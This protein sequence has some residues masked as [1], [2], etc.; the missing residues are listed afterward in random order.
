VT[1]DIDLN[2][3]ELVEGRLENLGSA[4]TC[5]A[6]S[7]GRA[8]QNTSD[9]YAYVCDG[10]VFR[11][12]VDSIHYHNGTSINNVKTATVSGVST[13]GEDTTIYLTD[14][15]TVNGNLL[16]SSVYHASATAAEIQSTV[17]APALHGY[18]YNAGTGALTLKF[19]ESN[20]AIV[21]VLQGLEAEE[22]GTPFTVFVV[23]V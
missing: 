6:G 1:N 23:G 9:G 8:Y 17:E 20:N 3:N 15:G 14:D 12:M 18:S 5:D 11:K 22:A 19:L 21:A 16:F 2:F 7:T 4:P 13:T 10:T